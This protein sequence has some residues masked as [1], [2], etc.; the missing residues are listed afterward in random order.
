MVIREYLSQY[1][2]FYNNERIHTFNNGLN[3]KEKEDEYYQNH[4]QK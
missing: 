3:P 2:N 4:P 1:F